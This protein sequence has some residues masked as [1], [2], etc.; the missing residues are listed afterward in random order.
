MLKKFSVILGLLGLFKSVHGY[1]CDPNSCKPPSCTCASQS[2]P[3]GISPN[4]APQFVLIS[5]DD[6]VNDSTFGIIK[7]MYKGLA[8]S[9]G[10]P[11]VATH[12]VQNQYTN[13]HFVQQLYAQGDEVSLYIYI[14][15]YFIY[16]FYFLIII[17]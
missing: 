3:G 6:A 12:F 7:N 5:Y 4:E 15:V 11:V 16:V 1:A 14:N 17:K 13:Y 10:C 2:P 9:N 8:H